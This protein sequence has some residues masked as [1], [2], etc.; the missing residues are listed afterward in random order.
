VKRIVFITLVAIIISITVHAQNV[1]FVASAPR[2]VEIGEQFE[3]TFT[4]TAQ[5]ASFN[6][7]EF[8]GFSLIGGPSTSSSSSVQFVNGKVSQSSSYSY[9]YYFMANTAGTFNIEPARAKVDGKTYSSNAFTIQVAGNSQNSNAQ[10]TNAQQTSNA[11]ASNQEVVA[12]SGNEDIFIRVLVDKNTLYQ[13]EHI[14]A[15]VKLFSRLNISQIENPESPSFNGFFRQDIEVPPLR[16]LDKEAVNGQVYGT[17]V[18]QKMVLFPQRNG[19]IIIDPYSMQLVVQMPVKGRQRSVFDDFW[20]PQVQEARKKV[21]SKPVK[22]IVKPL[23]S[24]APASF[25]GAVGNFSFKATLDKQNVKTNDAI[26]LKIAI[27]GNGNLKMI[28][29]FD[30]KFPSDFE[31]YDPKTTVNV[32]SNANGANGTKTFE[33][34]LIPRHS[35]NFKIEPIEFSYFDT[36]SKQYKTVSSGEFVINVEKGANEESSVVVTG[37]SKED[38]KFLGK[39]IQYIKTQK[40]EFLTIGTYFFASLQ[41]WLYYLI[42][43]LVFVM[44]I[45]LWRKRIRENANV[46]YV[47]NKRANKVAH[48]RLKDAHIF[49][50]GN[51]KEE[52]YEYILKAMWGYMSDKL[53]IPVSELSRE[54]IIESSANHK[55][56]EELTQK[57]LSILDT[58]EFA[59]YAPAEGTS[60]MDAV[61]ADS[62]DIISKIEQNIR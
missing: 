55:I 29:A 7:P 59:R 17:G 15:S 31:T 32:T 19:E 35:G 41:F 49:M 51:K 62:I 38:V 20:G 34:L 14:I 2:V 27:S 56:S 4:I 53:T 21:R 50:K 6:A 42:S 40:P 30:L 8:K 36:Q 16:Q 3:V 54:K 24:N 33:Y 52:F 25:K 11:S 60:Q 1:Q 43:L 46:V 48:K 61:Y 57:F 39:D 18:I 28:E 26:N 47:K 22:I 10:S 23:P 45:V 13:G 12:E 37:V 44:L 9:T 5:P 58:C